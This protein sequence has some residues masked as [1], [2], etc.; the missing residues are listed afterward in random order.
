MKNT[1]ENSRLLECVCDIAS[2]ITNDKFGARATK[3]IQDGLSDSKCIVWTDDA[4]NFYN[5][6]FDEIE[7]M[8]INNL[9]LKINK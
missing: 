9:K 2:M 6:M 3:E 5:D 1:I 4:Q 7:G 8:I